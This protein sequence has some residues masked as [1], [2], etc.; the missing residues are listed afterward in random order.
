MDTARLTLWQQLN[1]AWRLVATGMGFLV[2]GLFG[3][4]SKL[5]LWPFTAE[6]L[7]ESWRKQLH[8]RRVVQVSWWL[9]I[10]FLR[11]TG[12][13]RFQFHGAERLGQPGQLIIA[14]HPSLLDVVFMIA[15][16]R[17][18]NCVVKQDLLDNPFLNSP[19]RACGYIPNDGSIDMLEQAAAVL[20]NGEALLI[21]PEGTR[22][23]WDGKINFHRGAC[24][25][26]LRGARVITPVVV[27]MQPG[28]FKKGQP[29]YHIPRH[30]IHYTFTVG[31]DIDP[32]TWLAQKP[33]P[34]AARQLNDYLHHYFERELG[35]EHST[36]TR[37]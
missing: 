13:L 10:H 25:I 19:I 1:R 16:A 14:N 32:Q 34:I 28:N 12:V 15:Y 29:W 22:T 3:L 18:S 27:R 36:A 8:A 2:F 24:S 37:N 30:T 35:H 20:R 5:L 6:W 17:G 33:L 21:F 4:L 26:G 23:G 11:L 9:F 7:P 31:A